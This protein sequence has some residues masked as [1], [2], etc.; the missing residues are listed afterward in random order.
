MFSAHFLSVHVHGSKETKGVTTETLTSTCGTEI[1]NKK[2]V[3][4]IIITIVINIIMIR[5]YCVIIMCYY[6][7]YYYDN[8]Y[9]IVIII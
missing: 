8:V 4:Y 1:L 5:I 9:N 2:V 3:M 6:Y 7:Y